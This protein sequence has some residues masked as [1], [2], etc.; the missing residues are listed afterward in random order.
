M[1]TAVGLVHDAH[2]VLDRDE[3]LAGS[4]ARR[5]RCGPSVGRMSAV[6]PQTAWDRL[7]F[8]ETCAVRRQLRMARFGEL[9]VGGGPHEVACEAHEELGPPVAHGA[10]RVHGVQPVMA[11]AG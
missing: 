3:L 2:R 9:A 6:S 4:S 8:V 10:D 1:Q 7:S 11:S 5:G